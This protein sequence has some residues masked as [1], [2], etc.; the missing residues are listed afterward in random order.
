MDNVINLSAL[1]LLDLLFRFATA[2]E[3][4]LLGLALLKGG[5]RDTRLASLWLVGCLLG[6]VLL[7]A[8]I[9]NEHYGW[10]RPPL[11]LLT[12][13]TSYA[14]LAVYWRNVH[15][16]ALWS[17][18]PRWAKPL[19]FAWFAWLAY[20]YLALG[21]SGVFHDWHHWLLLFILLAIVFDAA[22]DLRDDLVE[23]RRE[24]RKLAIALITL[25]ALALTV[26]E[27]FFQPLKDAPLFS[28]FNALLMLVAGAFLFWRALPPALLAED[29]MAGADVPDPRKG[30]PATGVSPA[31]QRLLALMEQGVYR[32]NGLTISRLAERLEMPEH[33]LR[34]LINRQLGFDNFSRFLNSYRIPAVCEQLQKP[35]NKDTPILT[36]ALEAGF[37]SIATFNRAF[38][39]HTGITPS[40]YRAKKAAHFQN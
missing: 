12:N 10:L 40:Q 5:E 27:V 39:S 33:Q 9:A 16:S 23:R 25:Y 19:V 17:V 7:T 1:Q 3:L 20:F 14:L 38:K 24:L 15:G 32:E 29:S 26:L 13:C 34:A 11:L 21:G 18:L 30:N 6:Y 2:G 31:A 4:L 22:R 36:L 8:P 37:N 35:Q 28:L